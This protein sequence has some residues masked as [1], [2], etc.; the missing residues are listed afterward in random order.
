MQYTTLGR[1]GLRVSRLSLGTVEFG[2]PG[3]GIH[4]PGGQRTNADEAIATLHAA[5]DAG[6]RLFDTARNYGD[7]EAIVG[8][9]LAGRDCVIATKIAT[10]I[11][12][13]DI[14]VQ[15][16][17]SL[18]TSLRL[19]K[20]PV[21][22]LVQIHNATPE[23]IRHGAVLDA[24]ERAREAGRLRYIGASVYGEEA[25]LA[26]IRCGRIDVLQIAFSLLDQR[27]KD[28][29]LPE[30]KAS[31]VGIIARSILLKGALTARSQDLPSH[32]ADLA[33]ASDRVRQAMCDSWETLPGTA[34]R[35][36]LSQA[37]I[38]VVLVGVQNR[39]ELKGALSAAKAGALE[40]RRM[41]AAA[42]LGLTDERLLNPSYWQLDER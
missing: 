39:V 8:R 24:M 32:L 26:A 10:P 21:L 30:A 16:N 17:E 4:A 35:F 29:V 5:H 11:E 41:A 20:R 22:D 7:S 28:R 42:A 37:G 14:E 1:T 6:I 33:Q 38:D 15:V 12:G 3:Y 13:A 40:T 9:A 23:L 34:L 25:A 18:A 2:V 36:C 31:N 27:M 19:L